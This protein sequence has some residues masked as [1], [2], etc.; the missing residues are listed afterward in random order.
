MAVTLILPLAAPLGV[1]RI[2]SVDEKAGAVQI[3]D[4]TTGV[5]Y[6]VPGSVLAEFGALPWRGR[7]QGCTVEASAEGTLT[8]LVLDANPV[9][10]ERRGA[11]DALRGAQQAADDARD[12]AANWGGTDRRA[13]EVPERFW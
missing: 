7:V 13:H 8:E 9:G 3:R 10:A 12:Q 2:V 11:A 6:R 1:G 4:L 5:V